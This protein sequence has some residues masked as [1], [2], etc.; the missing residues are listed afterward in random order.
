MP[1]YFGVI[2]KEEKSDYGISWPDLPGCISAGSTLE[3]LDAMAREALQLHLEGMH[4]DGDAIP[5]PS[6]HDEVFAAHCDDDGF[7]G[8]VLVTVPDVIR[9][10]AISLRVAETDLDVIDRAATARGLNRTA[11][12]VQAAKREARKPAA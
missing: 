8:V 2:H 9:L 1:A 10:R 6:P 11:F 5:A 3:E 4:E 7:Y 12:M